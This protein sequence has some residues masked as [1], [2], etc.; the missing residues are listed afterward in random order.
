MSK[1]TNTNIDKLKSFPVDGGEIVSVAWCENL[2]AA[3]P[4]TLG[5]RFVETGSFYKV[6]FK[7]YPTEQ[8][9]ITVMMYLPEPMDWNGKFLGTGNG[10]SAGKVAEFTLINGIGRG[11]ATANTD[12]G[13][14]PDPDD[15]M[16]FPERWIDFGYRA[17][18]L[19][20]VVCKQLVTYFYGRQPEHAYFLGG[21]T[22]GQ[23][24]LSEAQRYPEDYDGIICFSPAYDR[25]RLHIFFVWNWLQIHSR[26]DA[27]FTPEQ[28][29]KWKDSIVKVYGE[30]AGSKEN[31]RFLAYP[32][33]ICENP[34]D[35]PALRQAISEQLT[36]GQKEALRSIYD[37][38]KDPVTGERIIPAFLPG[39]EAEDLSLVTYSD[40]NVFAHDTFYLF[41]WIW[42]QAFDFLKFDFHKDLQDATERLSPILD[43]T[44][45][46]LSA[47]KA[48]GGKLL[49][50]GGSTD[51]IIPYTGFLNY[52][53]E[54][55]EKQGGLDATREF[56]RFVLMPGLSHVMGGPGVQDLGNLGLLEVPR[57]P[58]HDVICAM[59]RWVEQGKVPERL[60][61]TCF[62]DGNMLKDYDHDRP[63]HPYPY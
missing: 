14:T 46:D 15:C 25:V 9:N 56:F 8:S 6:V 53:R 52:Y 13:T 1:T 31:D 2:E 59:E 44:N 60:L 43:A 12:M 63:A 32:D 42:G 39:T 62:K 4:N 49:V 27:T 21:S 24:G 5:L 48:S 33:R 3:M 22:G 10:G 16:A 51:A 47:F 45:P 58:E 17:T 57:D 54:A 34:M 50:I 38:P 20:T 23:Q 36:E 40:K 7:L 41:R 26:K 37:G 28:A 11:Y 61:G 35:N 18:H 30:A 55:M 29:S 19:M